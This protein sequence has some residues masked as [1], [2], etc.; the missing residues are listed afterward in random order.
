MLQYFTPSIFIFEVSACTTL[1]EALTAHI[2]GHMDTDFG[3][4]N[5]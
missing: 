5:P 4:V 1:C 2:L 3:D